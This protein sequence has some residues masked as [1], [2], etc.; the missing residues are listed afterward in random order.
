M[1]DLIKPEALANVKLSSKLSNHNEIV[2]NVI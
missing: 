2:N 1:N